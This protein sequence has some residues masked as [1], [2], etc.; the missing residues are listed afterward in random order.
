MKEGKQNYTKCVHVLDSSMIVMMLMVMM[1]LMMVMMKMVVMKLPNLAS[2]GQRWGFIRG[3]AMEDDCLTIYDQVSA[4][5][6]PLLYH[7]KPHFAVPNHTKL[8]KHTMK[9]WLT[10]LRDHLHL[11]WSGASGWSVA[12]ALQ[13]S[14][15]CCISSVLCE[16]GVSG[17]Q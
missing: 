3:W 10:I 13:R 8:T 5:S 17:W 7:T 1:I 6:D 14:A 12:D 2:R 16:A 11:L 4:S 9:V 15:K